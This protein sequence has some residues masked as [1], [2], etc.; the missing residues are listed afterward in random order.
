MSDFMNRKTVSRATHAVTFQAKVGQA[1]NLFLSTNQE[2]LAAAGKFTLTSEA[3]RPCLL[4]GLA[5]DA[6]DAGVAS[7]GIITEITVAGQSCLVSDQAACISAFS[8]TGLPGNTEE[9]SIGISVNN[10]MK[11]VIQGEILNVKGNIS[12]ALAIDPL[13]ESQ[14]KT[15][16]AQAEAYN[17]IF[18]CGKVSVPAA[19]SASL[20]ARSNRAVTLGRII[21]QNLTAAGGAFVASDSLRCTSILIQGLEML[22]GV[23]G[24]Q[25]ISLANFEAGVTDAGLLLNYPIAPQTEVTF[26]ISNKDAA[27]AAVVG[28]AIFC[29]PWT[30]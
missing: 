25:E 13:P 11:V 15:R 28:G 8:P 26:V 29:S 16:S 20:T 30:L 18:G 1:Q 12:M 6:Q 17:Y 27:N 21:L 7:E 5:I 2:R 3:Q 23:T 24:A 19:G 4:Q 10:N 9:R 14:V 22:N